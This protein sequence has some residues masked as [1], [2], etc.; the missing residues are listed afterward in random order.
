MIFL[1]DLGY[2]TIIFT[3]VILYSPT[4]HNEKRKLYSINLP[5]CRIVNVIRLLSEVDVF[6]F[7]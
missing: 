5:V 1:H 4:L 3:L 6:E 7:I 2:I